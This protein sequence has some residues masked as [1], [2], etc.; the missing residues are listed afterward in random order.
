MRGAFFISLSAVFLG[1]GALLAEDW[2]TY[3]HDNRRSGVTSE[4]LA[5]PL[6]ASW[7]YRSPV[8]PMTAW[9]GPAK[10]DAYSENEGLQSMRNFD[11]A[12]YVTAVGESVFF[13]SS[14]DNAAHCLD[15]K[16]GAE[17]WVHFTNS[18]VRLPPTV[19]QG[20]AW[21]GSDDGHAYCVDAVTGKRLWKR[22][23][24]NDPRMIPNNGKLISLWPI[25][26]GVLVQDDVAYFAG[27][28]LPWESSFLCA[29]DPSTGEP[30]YVREE[31]E[32]T[33]QGALLASSESLYAPQGRS[34]PLVYQLADGKRMGGIA[35][36]GGVY[37]VLTEDE[38]FI[39]MP[40]SQKEK[41]DTVR[42]S[43]GKRRQILVSFGGANRMIVSGP[44]AYSHQGDQLKVID[45]FKLIAIQGEIDVFL[46]AN[47]R[48][49]K[50]KKAARGDKERLAELDREIKAAKAEIAKLEASKAGCELWARKS[51][52]PIGFMLAGK[53]LYVGG[54]RYVRALNAE[55]GEP[56]WEAPVEGKAYGLA[57]ANGQLYV[58]TDRG[59]I[60]CF[61]S[62]S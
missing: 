56:L 26:S 3:Q 39:A 36:S 34:V 42:I 60:H 43:D 29:V 15:A 50:E 46:K 62:S 31:S 19:G 8:P 6:N 21:F 7:V 35:G 38:H 13:G 59:T 53:T 32:I 55:D 37:C 22:K 33:F 18:A 23:P 4:E 49:G 47:E 14:V 27:S 9:S 1:H 58:S 51:A 52:V 12:F 10:W 20:K 25:R 41:E 5:L 11:P 17:R 45:R 57:A 28:L 24:S 54:D 16:T 40:S 2:P 48:R 44:L 61:R 30:R